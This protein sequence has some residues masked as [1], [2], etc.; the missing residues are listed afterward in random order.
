MKERIATLLGYMTAQQAQ[1]HGFTNH[2]AMYGVPCWIADPDGGAPMVATKWAP[3]E[4][5]VSLG[6][7]VTGLQ[8][9]LLGVTPHFRIAVG[10]EIAAPAAR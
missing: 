2:G 3:M 4:W 8:M 10:R 6:H 1:A 9:D 5:F 7:W